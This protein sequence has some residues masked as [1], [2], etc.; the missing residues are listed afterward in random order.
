MPVP[1]PRICPKCGAAEIKPIRIV[2]RTITYQCRACAH[3]WRV[4]DYDDED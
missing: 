3:E 4:V 1:L 2:N